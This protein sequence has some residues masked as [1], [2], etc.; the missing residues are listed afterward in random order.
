MI[1]WSSK[2]QATVAGSSTEAEYIAASEAS[3]EAVSLRSL[4]HKLKL[5]P[6]AATSV[7]TKGDFNPTATTV[8]CD[9]NGA[10]VVS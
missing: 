5:L 10:I 2:H 4:L 3:R 1:S 6:D 8:F 9:N 7:Y